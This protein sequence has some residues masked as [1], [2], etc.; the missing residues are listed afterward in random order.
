MPDRTIRVQASEDQLRDLANGKRIF[1]TPAEF[2]C[3][4]VRGKRHVIGVLVE[5]R[6][7]AGL[8][9]RLDLPVARLI[10]S[11][12]KMPLGRRFKALVRLH[13]DAEQARD[14]TKARIEHEG[15]ESTA[16]GPMISNLRLLEGAVGELWAA[17]VRIGDQDP[18]LSVEV[19]RMAHDPT[20]ER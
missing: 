7:N 18:F 1:A 14:W 19:N 2:P 5:R 16:T 9:S 3:Q 12:N 20:E 4:H 17:I 8:C 11:W 10:P 15:P 13:R 6:E